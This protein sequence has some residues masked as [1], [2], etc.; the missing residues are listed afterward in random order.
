MSDLFKGD[1]RRVSL[2]FLRRNVDAQLL[3]SQ[4]VQNHQTR[5]PD[6]RVSGPP[7]IQVQNTA[8][9]PRGRSRG[10]AMSRRGGVRRPG[11]GRQ[12]CSVGDI[13]SPCGF[14]TPQQSNSIDELLLRHVGQAKE[15][16]GSVAGSKTSKTTETR[17]EGGLPTAAPTTQQRLP[18]VINVLVFPLKT[19]KVGLYATD[20]AAKQRARRGEGAGDVTGDASN[21]QW[22]RS[23]LGSRP[24]L[25]LGAAR[26]PFPPDSR[27]P[28][29]GGGATLRF[30]R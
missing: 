22:R 1:R 4:Q 18:F 19:Q 14:L 17:G 16:P 24:H 28:A 7:L 25:P 8:E 12:R 3:P 29:G 11:A 6:Q 9:A 15:P 10:T 5:G 26:G 30:A 13:L 21:S 23:L 20:E 27:M 2:P